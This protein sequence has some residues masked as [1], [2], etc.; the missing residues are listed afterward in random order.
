MYKEN[1]NEFLKLYQ[2]KDCYE[3]ITIPVISQSEILSIISTNNE[4]Q[5][6]VNKQNECKE[7]QEN[8]E[9]E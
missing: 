9:K 1:N 8:C 4:I 7:L 5:E 3:D 2:N 6:F